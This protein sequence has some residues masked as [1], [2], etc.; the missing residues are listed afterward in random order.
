MTDKVFKGAVDRKNIAL[1]SK[2][3]LPKR[4][5]HRNRQ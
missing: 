4:W 3:E 1:Q 5:C 2:K